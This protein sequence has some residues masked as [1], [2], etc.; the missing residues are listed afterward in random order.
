MSH[1]QGANYRMAIKHLKQIQANLKEA[2][3]DKNADLM[4]T[5]LKV[6]EANGRA[7]LNGIWSYAKRVVDAHLMCNRC[8]DED[9]DKYYDRREKALDSLTKQIGIKN[10]PAVDESAPT[11]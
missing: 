5:C 10:C 8:N 9:G 2:G 11:P 1:I 4:D 3:W 7:P 6:I